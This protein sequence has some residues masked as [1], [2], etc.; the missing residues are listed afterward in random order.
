M[1]KIFMSAGVIAAIVLCLVGIIK[2]PFGKFKKNSPKLYKAIFTILSIAL[3]VA[4]T[5]VEEIYISFGKVLSLN[6]AVKLTFVIA[7]VFCGY[8]GI[9]EGLGVK[10][11]IKNLIKNIGEAIKNKKSTDCDDIQVKQ[12]DKND[13]I[14]EINEV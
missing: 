11:L 13:K 5:I 1:E 4:V 9:Y 10:D 8:G 2:S 6:F 3:S 14:D 7:G 12:E